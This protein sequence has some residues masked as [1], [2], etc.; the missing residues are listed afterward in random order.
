MEDYLREFT[1]YIEQQRNASNNTLLSYRH[2]ILQFFS[3]VE[4]RVTLLNDVTNEMIHEYLDY[5]SFTGKSVSTVNRSLASIRSFYKFMQKSGYV[6]SNPTEKIQIKKAKKELPDILTNRE[7]DLLLSQPKNVDFKG[8]RDKAMLELLYAT[9]IRVSEL[10]SLNVEDVNL[11]LSLLRCRCG[12]T[13]ERERMIPIYPSAVQAVVQYIK[14]ARSTLLV[15]DGSL[16]VNFNGERMTRQGFWKIIKQYARQAEIKTCITPQTLRHSFATHLL[17]NGADLRSIQ[18][19]LGLSDIASTQ[20]Y[21]KLA[22]N[23]HQ[24]VYK[25]CHPRA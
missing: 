6:I 9:G 16:F 4:E 12:R 24:A 8:C 20:I 11:E 25:K 22:N 23:R 17:E 1:E 5:L 19:M 18:E 2:D 7:I 10:I 14:Q 13:G 3:F 21:V 15:N